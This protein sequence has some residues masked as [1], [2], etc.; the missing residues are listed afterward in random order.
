MPSSIS[1][2]S[3]PR[4][5]LSACRGSSE[6]TSRRASLPQKANSSQSESELESVTVRPE[7]RTAGVTRAGLRLGRARCRWLAS[8][9]WLT[10]GCVLLPL[11]LLATWLRSRDRDPGAGHHRIYLYA[12]LRV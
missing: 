9:K 2:C 3:E 6:L 11:L 5:Y 4:S 10:A 12:K 1:A 7:V 8:N